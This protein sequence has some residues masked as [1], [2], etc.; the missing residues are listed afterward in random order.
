[1][2]S[3][4]FSSL[5]LTKNLTLKN[6]IIMAPMGTNFASQQGYITERNKLYYKT[7][8]IGGVGLIIVEAAHLD[9]TQRHRPN[10]IR[11]SDDSFIAGLLE[12]TKVIHESDVPVFQQLTH[13]GR[14]ASEKITGVQPIAASPIPHPVSGEIPHSLTIEE[15]QKAEVMF[16]EAAMRVKKAGFDGVEIHG[17][18]GYLLAEFVSPYT[19]KRTDEYGGELNNRTRF[20][21]EIVSKI[22]QT[23]GPNFLISFRLS[24]TEFLPDGFCLDEAKIFAVKLER[25]GVDLLHISAG[26][27]EQPSTMVKTIPLLS[28]P[29]GCFA[30]FAAAI[31]QV[32]KIPIITVGRIDSPEVAEKILLE[33]Q[34][35]LIA[36]GRALIADPFWPVKAH[37]GRLMDINK[38]I[39]CN[40]GCIERLNRNECICCIVNPWVGQKNEI[41]QRF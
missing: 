16:A 39:A 12:L 6:R 11:I 13:P 8:A 27:N 30:H 26:N 22:R 23:V 38:C 24:A 2:F 40:K 31:K 36:L 14:L 33:G 17:G 3:N 4:L 20:P 37:E 9:P 18:H 25:A 34:A 28:T 19:N 5:Q 10:G 41:E 15:I 35:D 1:M 29:P 7:R 32:V 21:L